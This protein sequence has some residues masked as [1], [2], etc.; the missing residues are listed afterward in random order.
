MAPFG[1]RQA[2]H[3]L[4]PESHGKLTPHNLRDN[5]KGW[6][7]SA[8]FGASLLRL[9][10]PPPVI[11]E[12]ANPERLYMSQRSKSDSV[13]SRQVEWR[14]CP[15]AL[16]KVILLGLKFNPLSFQLHWQVAVHHWLAVTCYSSTCVSSLSWPVAAIHCSVVVGQL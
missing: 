7:E 6:G 12:P 10:G 11:Q 8:E 1:S 5:G 9:D 4:P 3:K 14:N 2:T 15:H 13:H 16:G